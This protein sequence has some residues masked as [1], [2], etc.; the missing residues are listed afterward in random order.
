MID[1]STIPKIP[2]VAASFLKFGIIFHYIFFYLGVGRDLN[3]S[4]NLSDIESPD[5]YALQMMRC[6]P[7]VIHSWIILDC[8]TLDVNKKSNSI[9]KVLLL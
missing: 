7:F 5:Y 4:D 9:F 2:V 6:L 3:L 1:R 8:K